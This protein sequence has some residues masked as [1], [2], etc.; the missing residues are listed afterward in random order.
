MGNDQ[1]LEQHTFKWCT[2]SVVYVF[3]VWCAHNSGYNIWSYPLFWAHIFCRI[4]FSKS[5]KRRQQRLFFSLKRCTTDAC[6]E[7]ESWE[8][9]KSLCVFAVMSMVDGIQAQVFNFVGWCACTGPE[10]IKFN[11]QIYWFFSTSL[12]KHSFC[13]W[14]FW[15]LIITHIIS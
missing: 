12:L 8:Y 3:F 6:E 9:G 13:K 15:K 4:S 14:L 11:W 10:I 5:L 2:I 7:F 1:F